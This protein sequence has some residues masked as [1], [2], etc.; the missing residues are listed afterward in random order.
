MIYR[1]QDIAVLFIRGIERGRD[2]VVDTHG[3][4]LERCENPRDECRRTR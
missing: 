4:D 2:H 1:F 3:R